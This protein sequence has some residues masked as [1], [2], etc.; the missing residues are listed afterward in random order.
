MDFKFKFF[1]FLWKTKKNWPDNIELRIVFLDYR[2]VADLI[3]CSR[4]SSWSLKM[5][6]KFFEDF[7]HWI[8]IQWHKNERERERGQQPNSIA[9]AAFFILYFSG[10]FFLLF[11]FPWSAEK[12][13]LIAFGC[14]HLF[15]FFWFVCQSAYVK[16]NLQ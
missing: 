6:K 11:S 2:S 5:R 9:R 7:C 12:K 14:H 3:I 1:C 8:W 15:F 13:T 10:I 16:S 4:W